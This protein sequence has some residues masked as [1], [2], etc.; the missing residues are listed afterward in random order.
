MPQNPNASIS[1]TD[2]VKRYGDTP[3]TKGEVTAPLS[4]V[5][6]M[7]AAF[8]TADPDKLQDPDLRVRFLAGLV[9]D[10]LD[11]EDRYLLEVEEKP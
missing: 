8:C 5:L 10:E 2:F 7:E 4:A 1:E 6:Q 11:P 9:G 3:V